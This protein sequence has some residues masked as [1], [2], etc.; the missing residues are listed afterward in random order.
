MKERY[1][2]C[3]IRAWK[4]FNIKI[5]FQKNKKRRLTGR[6]AADAF[7]DSNAT[8]KQIGAAVSRIFVLLY[9]GKETDNLS[10]FD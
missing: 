10:S 4:S 5:T 9:G 3:D 7:P 2:I 1:Y 6:E 8:P